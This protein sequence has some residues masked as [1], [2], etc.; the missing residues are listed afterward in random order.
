MSQLQLEVSPFLANWDKMRGEIERFLLEQCFDS[1]MR[2]TILLCC[3]EWFVNIVNHGY[4]QASDESLKQAEIKLRIEVEEGQQ[5]IVLTFIDAGIPFNPLIYTKPQLEQTA[6][7]RPIGGLGIF[8]IRA[9]MD[10]CLYE[11][12]G[13]HNYFTMIK[14]LQVN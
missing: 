6:E 14:H 13:E 1:K 2:Y 11:Y 8:F 3:E 4:V 12:K 5:S 7:E 10:H 9:K